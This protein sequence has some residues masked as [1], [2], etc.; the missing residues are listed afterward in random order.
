MPCAA[1]ALRAALSGADATVPVYWGNRNWTRS[2]GTSWRRS[3]ADGHRRVL[4][5]TTS[6]YPS[7][8]SC[9][10]YRENLYD[11]VN[12]SLVREAA[13][14]ETVRIDRIRHYAN[15]PGFVAASVDAADAAPGR[16]RC[17]STARSDWCSSRT[18]SPTAMADTSGP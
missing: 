17:Q 18:P 16:A 12:A 9:R 5:L 13:Q 14:G 4:A 6:A 10:Q 11:A 2:W 15:H 1:A 3:L 7:Y 8:S